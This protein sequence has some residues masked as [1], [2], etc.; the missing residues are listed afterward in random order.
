MVKLADGSEQVVCIEDDLGLDLADR[1]KVLRAL[2]AQGCWNAV[3]Y[4]TAM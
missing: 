4:T 1:A 2:K 3:D